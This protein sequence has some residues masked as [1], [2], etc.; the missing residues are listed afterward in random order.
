MNQKT[1]QNVVEFLYQ[2]TAIH[3]LVNPKNE[4]VMVNATEMAKMFGKRT[5]HYLQ[6]ESTKQFIEA[7]KVPDM[8][9][10]LDSKIIDNRG[11]NGIYFHR[12]LALDFAAWLDV[13]FRVWIIRTIDEILFAKNKFVA[14]A[15]F[16]KQEIIKERE[17]LI[18]KAIR[19]NNTDVL[20]YLRLEKDIKN[21]TSSEN[22]AFSELKNQYKMNI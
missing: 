13:N 6:N 11:R 21:L 12:I 8:S 1:Q 16:L 5:D 14:E 9:G 17:E 2:E 10:T 22:K 7:L 3:F 19:E 15:I 4:N 18:E 20:E